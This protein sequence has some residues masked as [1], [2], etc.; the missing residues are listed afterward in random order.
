MT[1]IYI[2][3]QGSYSDYRILGA[4]IDKKKAEAFV[5]YADEC[6]GLYS[7]PSEIEEYE[8]T[9]IPEVKWYQAY[10]KHNS[11]EVKAITHIEP[12]K[13]EKLT[14]N[15]VV[16]YDTG[17]WATEDKPDIAYWVRVVADDANHATKIAADLFR[18]F[19]ALTN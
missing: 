2:V 8:D 19:K 1:T 17:S 5:E 16:Q 3:T 13:S 11:V 14:R 6:G 9:E 12:N 15:N 10:S 7:E 4:F 18:Q